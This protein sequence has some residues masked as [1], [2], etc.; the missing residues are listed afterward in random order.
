[1]RRLTG[2]D[3]ENITG[4]TIKGYQVEAVRIKDG[5]CTDSDHYGFILG[6]NDKGHYVTWH[7]HLLDD[8]SISVYWGHYF[9]ENQDA[10][11][12]DFNNRDRLPT[13]QKFRVTITETMERT[14][15]VEADNRQQA[16]QMVSDGWHDSRYI[17]G[18]EDFT[19]VE[20]EA[21]PVVDE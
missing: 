8:D 16:E 12:R 2:R 3:L 9:M 6:K 20:F 21:V 18:S 14:V 10:A 17:L 19:G 1:M 15:E 4:R 13:P 5:P 7:F 11:I